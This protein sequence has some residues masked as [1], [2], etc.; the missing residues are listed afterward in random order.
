MLNSTLSEQVPG[1]NTLR[2][3]RKSE[4]NPSHL[5]THIREPVGKTI[6]QF[7][8]TSLDQSETRETEI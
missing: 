5:D 6:E 4:C 8:S 1:F 2:I 7:G 3:P